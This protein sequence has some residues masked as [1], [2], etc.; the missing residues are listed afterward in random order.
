MPPSTVPSRLTA[1]VA[2]MLL[3]GFV[4]GCSTLLGGG[5]GKAPDIYDLSA[6]TSFDGIRGRTG[7]Q[8]L[9]PVPAA[10]DALATPRLVVRQDG[11]Q[12]A[13]YPGL[14]WSDDLPALVQAK[15]VRA[16]E[17][18][19]RAKAVGRP[20]ESLAIDYQVIVD[21]RSF[22]L[23]ADAR[24]AHVELGVKL[25]DDRTGKVRATKVFDARVPAASDAAAEVVKAIDAAAGQAFTELVLWTAATI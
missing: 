25:L 14:T 24:T 13:Y 21:I 5:G 17:N 3:A 2:A 4:G 9:V 10:I 22:E 20:G 19:G 11:A 12:L 23:E 7:A 8:L 18:S 15:L 16:F 6:P 1:V